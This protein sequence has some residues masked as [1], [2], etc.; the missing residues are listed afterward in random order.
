MAQRARRTAEELDTNLLAAKLQEVNIAARQQQPAHRSPFDSGLHPAP[1]A[2]PRAP[3]GS[4]HPPSPQGSQLL[5]VL[6]EDSP[7]I[8]AATLSLRPPLEELSF[9]IISQCFATGPPPQP[10]AHSGALLEPRR[11][12]RSPQRPPMRS[13]P[14]DLQQ[15]EATESS[16]VSSRRAPS[17]QRDIDYLVTIW[18]G[19]LN[20]TTYKALKTQLYE[21]FDRDG[22]PQYCKEL[23]VHGQPTRTLQIRA[24]GLFFLKRIL[25]LKFRTTFSPMTPRKVQMDLEFRAPQIQASRWRHHKQRTSATAQGPNATEGPPSI[26]AA[27]Q[28][29]AP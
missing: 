27:A 7:P 28:P 23:Y 29:A 11:R 13:P 25:N 4:Q 17:P 10:Q 1:S 12:G 22:E 3:Q 21:Y 9:R 14:K 16:L 26:R 18:R 2:H 15:K 5:D 6:I 8:A 20:V 24:Y 19:Q